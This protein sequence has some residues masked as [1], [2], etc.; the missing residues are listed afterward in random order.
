MQ[1]EMVELEIRRNS[2]KI[3][4][5]DLTEHEIDHGCLTGNFLSYQMKF[6]RKRRFF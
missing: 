2:L 1:G 6:G 4:V 3:F 5:T